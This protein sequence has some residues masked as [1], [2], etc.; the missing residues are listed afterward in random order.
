MLF[1]EFSFHSPM[2]GLS[3][4]HAMPTAM[5]ETTSN[6][7][8]L[9]STDSS[10]DLFRPRDHAPGC[11]AGRSWFHFYCTQESRPPCF[12]TVWHPWRISLLFEQSDYDAPQRSLKVAQPV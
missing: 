4:A 8:V 1:A 6:F 7:K 11:A 2:K 12:V 10:L 3:A 9:F 5:L